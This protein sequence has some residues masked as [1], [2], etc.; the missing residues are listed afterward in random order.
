MLQ[1]RPIFE[2]RAKVENKRWNV[3]DLFLVDMTKTELEENGLTDRKMDQ[4]RT[5]K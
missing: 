3:G 5:I 1:W 2:E 4:K